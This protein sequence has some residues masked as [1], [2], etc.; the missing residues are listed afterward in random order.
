MLGRGGKRQELIWCNNEF[1]DGVE[2]NNQKS[3]HPLSRALGNFEVNRKN[4]NIGT[5][6]NMWNSFW[7]CVVAGT[8]R[9]GNCANVM[10]WDRKGCDYSVYN[11]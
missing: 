11:D 6:K 9:I 1:T 8:G 4:L 10:E 3:G 2:S 5:A 7:S